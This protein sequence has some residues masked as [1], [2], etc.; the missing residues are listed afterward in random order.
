MSEAASDH[1]GIRTYSLDGGHNFRDMGGYPTRDGKHTRWRWLFRSGRLTHL[2]EADHQ[3]IAPLGINLI[4][5][6]RTNRERKAFPTHWAAGPDAELWSR[7]HDISRA[8]LAAAV[9]NGEP[10][11]AAVLEVTLNLYR[12]LPFEQ[13][14][15][16]TELLKRIAAGQLP[17]VF[18]C[19]A[20]KDRTGAFAAILL[21]LLGVDRE[22]II[23]DYLLS[24]EFFD[25][26]CVM[27][28]KDREHHDMEHIEVSRLEPLLRTHRSYLDVMF[29]TIEA[30]HGSS[31]GYVR[32]AL[33]ISDEEIAAIRATLLV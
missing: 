3:A 4:F 16:Y 30:K 21:D 12:G 1:G 17:L 26:L 2:T 15:S 14:A 10:G 25:R 6:L 7:D 20:G 32:E 19:S 23:E 28:V 5:D 9:K 33:G 13:A 18:H 27:F 22:T 31:K 8:D 24:E 11:G 29:E